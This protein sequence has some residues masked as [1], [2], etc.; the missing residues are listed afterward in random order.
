MFVENTINQIHKG[1]PEGYTIKGKIDFDL[2]LVHKD[3]GGGRLDLKVVGI[4]GEVTQE[5]SQ[6]VKFSIAPTNEAEEYEK[7]AK[8]A[9]AEVKKKDAEAKQKWLEETK[10][11]LEFSR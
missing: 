6:R 9:E 11:P 5:Q 1:L 2:S 8:I 10:L 4:G 7:K 3:T